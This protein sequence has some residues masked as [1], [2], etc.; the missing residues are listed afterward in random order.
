MCIRDRSK[1]NKST[2]SSQ[3]K[4]PLQK[5]QS[6]EKTA[7]EKT[8]E[9]T[10]TIIKKPKLKSEP[11][12][13]TV[14]PFLDKSQ[15]FLSNNFGKKLPDLDWVGISKWSFGITAGIVSNPFDQDQNGTALGAKIGLTTKYQFKEK[16]ALNA[17]LI[18]FYRT[19]TYQPVDSVFEVTGY[20]FG[21]STYRFELRPEN[22]HY[23]ELPIYL[24]YPIKRHLF[25]GGISASYLL[26]VRGST[27]LIVDL[28]S[29]QPVND[30]GWINE[31]GFR[32]FTANVMLGYQYKISS[33]IHFGVRAIYSPIGY[34]NLSLDNNSSISIDRLAPQNINPFHL[35][36]KL[37]Q[38][39]GK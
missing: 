33:N 2:I 32:K 26:G 35:T 36:I 31:T 17:D 14:I 11:V 5:S 22:S 13:K 16:L 6:P 25:E 1:T 12:A 27:R 19:G 30:T 8:N 10:K 29:S 4:I 28:E 24:T 3:P 18:Y 39:F 7:S 34:N 9:S 23:L 37:T 21:R 15:S 20:S 38:Y